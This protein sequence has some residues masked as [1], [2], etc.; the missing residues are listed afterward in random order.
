MEAD[1]SYF[2]LKKKRARRRA[3]MQQL[4]E[5]WRSCTRDNVDADESDFVSKK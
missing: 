4:L 1:E 2:V 3:E 5:V